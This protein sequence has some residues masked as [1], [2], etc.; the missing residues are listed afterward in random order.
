MVLK[1]R[2]QGWVVDVH[3]LIAVRVN[4]EGHREMLGVDV[5]TA[6]DGVAGWLAFWRSLTVRGSVRGEAGTSDAHAG[7]VAAIG[8]PCRARRGSA[9]ERFTPPI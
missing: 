6:E 2:E 4:A 9:A 3:A 1:V 8:G 7:L 5:S